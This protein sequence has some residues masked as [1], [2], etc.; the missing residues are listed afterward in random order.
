MLLK[1]VK[2]SFLF[3]DYHLEYLLQFLSENLTVLL[4]CLY[5]S[6]SVAS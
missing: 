5:V 1:S 2:Q 3:L 6:I 4:C